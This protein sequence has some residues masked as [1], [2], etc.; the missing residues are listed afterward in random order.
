MKQAS[1]LS[2]DPAARKRRASSPHLGFLRNGGAARFCRPLQDF[3]S[4]RGDPQ[5]IAR[6]FAKCVQALHVVVVQLG[7]P[8]NVILAGHVARALERIAS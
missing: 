7:S 5:K 3:P 6:T 8:Y 2:M 1:S 4:S